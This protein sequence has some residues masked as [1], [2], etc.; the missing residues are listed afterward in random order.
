MNRTVCLYTATTINIRDKRK[1]EIFCVAS[2]FVACNS[3]IFGFK[4]NSART[5]KSLKSNTEACTQITHLHFYYNIHNRKELVF[6]I[7]Y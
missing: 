6:T 1:F 4:C 3:N 2:Y 7:S 5:Q